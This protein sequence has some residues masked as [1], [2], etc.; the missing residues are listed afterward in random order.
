M[1]FI[2]HN[3]NPENIQTEDCVIRALALFLEDSWEN[4]YTDLSM[5][6][7][8]MHAMPSA[9]NVWG[10]YLK[11]NGYHRITIPDTCPDC[12][13]IRDFA[14]EHPV[15][16]YLVGTRSHVVTVID[17]NYYDAWDCGNEVPIYYW[18]KEN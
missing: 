5:Q 7:F 4:I 11:S 14:I 18:R 8:Y 16:K 3:E 9:N 1:S 12:Y 15:W 2:Y 10:R 6:G 13:T 17:G